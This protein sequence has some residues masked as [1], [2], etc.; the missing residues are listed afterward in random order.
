MERYR[1]LPFPIHI[2]LPAGLWRIVLA[3]G[4]GMLVALSVI[5]ATYY[6]EKWKLAVGLV[7]GVAFV[8]V[9]MWRP[10]YGVLALVGL[11]NGLVSTNWLPLLPVGPFSLHLQDIILGLLLLLWG[12][13]VTTWPGY[14][15]RR[16]PLSLPLALFLGAIVISAA[17]GIVLHQLS[18]NTV[19][20]RG[21]CLILWIAFFPVLD[22]VRDRASLT[23]LLIGLWVLSMVLALGVVFRLIYP[24]FMPFLLPVD[25][26]SLRTMGT[27][28]TG[29][30]RVFQYRGGTVLYAMIPV[31]LAMLAF[32]EGLQFWQKTALIGLLILFLNWLL[33]S[34]QRS[35]WLTTMLNGGLLLLLIPGRPRWQLVQALLPLVLL[36][37]LCGILYWHLAPHSAE[38]LVYGLVNRF[39]SLG[40]DV[41]HRD[42]SV[43]WRIVETKYG[44]ASF[45]RHPLF[46][47]GIGNEYRPPF[48]RE[49][50]WNEFGL[51]W[52][53]HNSYLWLAVMMG[54]VGLVP[55]LALCFVYVARGLAFWRTIADASLRAVYLGLTLGFLGQMISNIAQPTFLDGPPQHIYPVMMALN[56]VILHITRQERAG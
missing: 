45:L 55:F 3:L 21:R 33:F 6:F 20:R 35:L 37:L 14:A 25:V 8:L 32:R 31:T 54:L 23:R 24:S 43:T 2:R 42:D 11:T 49:I 30:S 7:G 22:L 48:E 10:E 29:V 5:V 9:T 50:W 51:R 26:E 15:R 40:T 56:E 38:R 52:F 39:S 19:L 12:L 13:R 28:I 46:G 17:N 47:I 34:F 41:T 36:V 1:S 16:T 4:T 27:E 18:A 44:M 53:I